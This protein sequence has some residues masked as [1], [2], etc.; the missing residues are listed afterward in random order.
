MA[1]YRR[2]WWYPF[3][4][5]AAPSN[6]GESS[7]LAERFLVCERINGAGSLDHCATFSLY[8]LQEPRSCSRKAN[9]E[10]GE[11]TAQAIKRERLASAARPSAYL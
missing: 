9:A 8:L 3:V 1:A 5:K 6:M 11:G 4:D 10:C 7:Q 2:T